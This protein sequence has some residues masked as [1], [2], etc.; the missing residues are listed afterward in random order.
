MIG[1]VP[2]HLSRLAQAEAFRPLGDARHPVFR[3]D[4]AGYA[5]F[6]APGYVSVVGLAHA[7][8]F[9]ACLG[10]PL[11]GGNA[12]AAGEL[13]QRAGRAVLEVERQCAD[14]FSPESLTLYLNNECNLDCVYCYADPAGGP[15]LRLDARVIAAG[16]KEVALH[17]HR[18][19]LP[20]TAVFHGGGE[21][22]LHRRELE[23]ALELVEAAAAGQGIG[24]FRYI[25]TNGCLSEEAVAWLA[26]HFDLVGLSC[27]GPPEVQDRQ[28]PRRG[29]GGTSAAVARTAG[30]LRR[31]GCRFHVRTTITPATLDRQAEI[32]GYICRQLAPEEI[33][34]EP[35][36]RGRRGD[37]PEARHAAGFVHHL[38][39]ARRVARE[40]GVPLACSASRPAEIHGPYCHVFRQTVN[41]IPGG[42]ATACFQMTGDAQ[43]LEKGLE[44]GRF[45]QAAG[46][47]RV[48][49]ARVQALRKMLGVLPEECAECFNRYHCVRGC[50][51]R[52]PLDGPGDGLG[53]RCRVAKS[54]TYATL[55]EAAETMWAERGKDTGE[56]CGASIR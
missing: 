51:D 28:R 10:S 6:Y 9:E 31:E 18:K 32:A 22:T 5:L 12:S 27:D 3:W 44:I 48:D 13:W 16:A 41:L 53:F 50:P 30:V 15:S 24:C 25:A 37:G 36:Y 26:H 17:C 34:F 7:D 2:P 4:R 42:V 8:Q 39:E 47:F 14:P 38:L 1:L 46:G 55:V 54:L 11:R 43:T 52:C 29:G 35:V 19:G 23:R 56:A 49:Q 45:D 21:P 20:L 40:H 33:H